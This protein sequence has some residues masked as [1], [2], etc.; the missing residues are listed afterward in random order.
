M[1]CRYSDV[2]YQCLKDELPTK[3]A[4]V[5]QENSNFEPNN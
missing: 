2:I 1:S 4:L 5:K 3:M